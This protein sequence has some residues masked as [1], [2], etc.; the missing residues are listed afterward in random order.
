ME[1]RCTRRPKWKP[2]VRAPKKGK[3]N[4]TRGERI[5]RAICR[6]RKTVETAH[7]SPTRLLTVN[8]WY[9]RKIKNGTQG[10]TKLAEVSEGQQGSRTGEGGILSG[11]SCSNISQPRRL[12]RRV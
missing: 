10:E 6:K 1:E 11:R 4:A 9:V 5:G 8:T 3:R 2:F 7:L 12:S